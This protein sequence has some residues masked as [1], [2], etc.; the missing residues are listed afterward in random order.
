MLT[1]GSKNLPW[2]FDVSERSTQ[3][4]LDSKHNT[5]YLMKSNS[6]H[7]NPKPS[8]NRIAASNFSRINSLLWYAGNN[9]ALKHVCAVGS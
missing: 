3:K 9:N 5:G 2:N 8:L 4:R 6:F 1:S 7:F